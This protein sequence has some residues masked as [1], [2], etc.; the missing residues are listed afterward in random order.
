MKYIAYLPPFPNY[1]D[2]HLKAWEVILDCE[3]KALHIAEVNEENSKKCMNLGRGV[4]CPTLVVLDNS[5][6]EEYIGYHYVDLVTYLSKNGL[7][8]C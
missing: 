1:R 2:D 5:G 8:L 6:V 7:M 4:G 3:G